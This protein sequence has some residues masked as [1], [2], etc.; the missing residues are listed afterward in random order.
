MRTIIIILLTLTTCQAQTTKPIPTFDNLKKFKK[1][2]YANNY[3]MAWYTYVT[4]DVPV[5]YTL[6]VAAH[7]TNYGRNGR[8]KVGDIFGTGK[9]YPL[10]NAWDEWGLMMKTTHNFIKHKRAESIDIGKKTEEINLSY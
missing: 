2:F 10:S 6:A 7:K 1:E 9:K 3:N 5:Y 8:Y 4:W